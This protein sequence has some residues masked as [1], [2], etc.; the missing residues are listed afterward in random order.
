[1]KKQ[2]KMKNK[3]LSLILVALTLMSCEDFLNQKPQSDLTSDL[4]YK[5]ITEIT[6]GVNGC[7]S[8]LLSIYN[9]N[10]LARVL[11]MTADEYS[12]WKMQFDYV[13]QLTKNYTHSLDGVWANS[14]ATIQRCN[15]MFEVIDAG[16]FKLDGKADSIALKRLKGEVSF[17]RAFTYFNMVRIWGNVPMVTKTYNIP[18]EAVGIGRTSSQEIY[19]KVIIPDLINAASNCGSKTDVVAGRATSGAANALLAK[20]YLTIT[21]KDY[22]KAEQAL[23][24]VIASTKYTLVDNVSK[25]VADG[26]NENNTES[27]FELQYATTTE[28]AKFP[29]WV[30]WEIAPQVKINS[31][32]EALWVDTTMIGDM[33]RSG[34]TARLNAWVMQTKGGIFDPYPKKLIPAENTLG[35]P[36][37][38]NLVLLRYSDVILMKAE[39]MLAQSKTID[40]ATLTSLNAIRTRAGVSTWAVSD[41][42]LNNIIQERRFELC[43]EGHRWFDLLRWGKAQEVLGALWKKTIPADQL[44]FPVPQSEIEKDPSLFPNNSGY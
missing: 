18:S 43:F 36:T 22:V 39:A 37:A 30:G 25:L 6:N 9:G 1:M 3:F 28:G 27:I 40:N 33:K 26:A 15:R 17:I 11:G 2:N 7:Y 19:N 38:T 32:N 20:A 23:D 24:A 35:N 14:Y 8:P 34:N 16:K 21:P 41:V 5:N 13:D 42:T 4:Y 31:S 29:S 10:G 12:Q 44:L